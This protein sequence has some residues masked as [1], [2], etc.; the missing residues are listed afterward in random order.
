VISAAFTPEA[1]PRLSTIACWP[2]TFV[3]WVASTRARKSVVPPGA[4]GVIVAKRV[5]DGIAALPG[6]A[7]QGVSVSAGVA[8]FPRDAGDSESLIEAAKAALD[9]AKSAGAGSVA[10][11]LPAPGTPA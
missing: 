10:D 8:T 5:Q 2:Q 3:R 6:V 9:R 7:G 1:L 11:A 4:A